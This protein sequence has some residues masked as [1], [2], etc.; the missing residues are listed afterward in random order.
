MVHSIVML[1]TNKKKES[2]GNQIPP[3]HS[4]E[5]VIV[6]Q[7][8]PHVCSARGPAFHGMQIIILHNRG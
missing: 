5:Q 4:L 3:R 2:M 7:T 1:C 6:D 8:G